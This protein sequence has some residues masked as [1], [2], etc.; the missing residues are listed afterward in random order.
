[1]SRFLL[2]AATQKPY[3]ESWNDVQ[4]TLEMSYM[5]SNIAV[6]FTLP[7]LSHVLLTAVSGTLNPEYSVLLH[8]AIRKV[9]RQR[10]AQTCRKKVP[11]K[12]KNTEHQGDIGPNRGSSPTIMN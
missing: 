2:C 5:K 4:T 10:V 1:M 8:M 6:V 11:G 12:P 7:V 9:L 3:W